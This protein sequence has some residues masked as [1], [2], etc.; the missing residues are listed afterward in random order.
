M[1][2]A[3]GK[4]NFHLILGGTY[5]SFSHESSFSTKLLSSGNLSSPFAF[6]VKVAQLDYSRF[7]DRLQAL[8]TG[9]VQRIKLRPEG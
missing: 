1:F 9:T 7:S 4:T 3:A 6:N 5:K 8:V 2:S